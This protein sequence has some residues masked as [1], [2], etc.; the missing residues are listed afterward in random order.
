MVLSL[1][2]RQVFLASPGGLDDERERIR[3]TIDNHN[4]RTAFRKDVA[5]IARGW[6]EDPGGLGRPQGIINEILDTCDFVIVVLADRWG[7]AP[8]GNGYTSGTEEEFERAL[9]L[10]GEE[11]ASMRDILVLF[12]SVPAGQ[13][14]DPGPELSKVLSFKEK[15]ERSKKIMYGTFDDGESL[16]EKIEAVLEKWGSP[17]QPRIPVAITLDSLE[18]SVNTPQAASTLERAQ[19]LA[20]E[21]SLVQA[22]VLF[23]KATQDDEPRALT[24]FAR[25]LRR[26]GRMSNSREL[27]LRVVAELAELTSPTSEQSGYLSDSLANI[28][29]VSRKRGDLNE[30]LRSLAE[31][32]RVARASA[33]PVPRELAYALDNLGHTQAQLG[34]RDEAQASFEAAEKVRRDINDERGLL[35][36]LLNR[37]WH[38]VR[39]SEYPSAIG[40][41]VEAEN[42]ARALDDSASLARALAGRGSASL[43]SGDAAAA[44]EPLQESL[45]LNVERGQSDG[46][47]IAAGLLA[48]AYVAAGDLEA[49]LRSAKDTLEQSQRSTNVTGIV[50]AKWALGQIASLS[51]RAADAA[52]LYD[53]AAALSRSTGNSALTGA[54]E[55]DYARIAGS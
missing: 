23:A 18:I 34:Y 26:Q 24:E 45:R 28:G 16:T 32:V 13:M 54:I 19:V 30:S 20:S 27:N 51:G 41:F 9:A 3:R 52:A 55:R 50:T 46:I 12:R 6:E 47:S 14:A 25:F 40:C 5:F 31:A 11:G 48:K 8:G 22:E 15:L 42:I 35:A 10:C 38:A 49:A 29:V 4:R 7:S 36:S 33:E 43:K 1:S 53:E 44:I 17:L 21:G 39:G 2:G 37:G